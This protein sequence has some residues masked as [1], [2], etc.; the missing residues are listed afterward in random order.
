MWFNR[1]MAA[2]GRGIKFLEKLYINANLNDKSTYE[3]F[4]SSSRNSIPVLYEDNHL[5]IVVKPDGILSQSDGSNAPDMLTLLKEYIKIKSNKPGDVFLGLVHRLDRPVSGVMIFAK[6]SKSASRISEQI[7]EKKVAKKYF[8]ITHGA[9]LKKEGKLQ[10]KL[11]KN[12]GNIVSEEEDGKEAILYYKQID[13]NKEND[14]SL[15]DINLETGRSHQIRVQLSNM[16]NPILGDKKYGDLEESYKG[17][18]A[19]FSYSFNFKH[20]TKDLEIQVRVIPLYKQ[21]WRT[22]STALRTLGNEFL[23]E[24]ETSVNIENEA[25]S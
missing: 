25:G 23:K 18:I 10:T 7:R 8:A 20:P 24:V 2:E 15:V 3:T 13:Y 12:A 4:M 22:F 14:V 11:L 16:G 5:L 21:E 19:L 17:E 1:Q 6:T 9:L